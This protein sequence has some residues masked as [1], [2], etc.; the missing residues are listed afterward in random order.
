MKIDCIVGIDPGM[1][2]G[3]AVWRPNHD[4]QVI[5]M[6][7]VIKEHKTKKTTS[8][9]PKKFSELDVVGFRDYF[10]YL[11]GICNPLVFIEKLN[12]RPSDL[13]VPGKAFQIEKMMQNFEQMKALLISL[14][15]PYCQVP[16]Q[17]WQSDLKLKVSGLKHRESKDERKNRYCSIAGKLYPNINA[18]KWNSDAVLIAHFGRYICVNGKNWVYQNLPPALHGKVF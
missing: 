14:D 15:I 13:T 18:T 2:G 3:I 8:G 16:P 12:T 6:P 17:K 10:S 5:K 1:S 4:L 11:Q 7:I 9:K